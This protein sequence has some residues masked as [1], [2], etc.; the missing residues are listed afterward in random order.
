MRSSSSS[1]SS[2]PNNSR[3]RR[4]STLARDWMWLITPPVH[5]AVGAAV[6]LIEA[7]YFTGQQQLPGSAGT[8]L[9][10]AIYLTENARATVRPCAGWLHCAP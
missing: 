1:S 7:V 6:V 3:R 10:G 4:S 5:A 2:R 9:G 8:R